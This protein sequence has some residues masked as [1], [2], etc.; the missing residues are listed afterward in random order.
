MAISR[1]WQFT[2]GA[3][4]GSIVGVYLTVAAFVIAITLG[5]ALAYA[6]LTR[7]GDD[8]MTATAAGFLTGVLGYGLFHVTA[9]V[10]NAPFQ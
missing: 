7:D 2:L 4:L 3:V 10:S 1:W 6:S 9:L 8:V 5:L